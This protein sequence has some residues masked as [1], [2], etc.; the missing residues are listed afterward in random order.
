MIDALKREELRS[1]LVK[2]LGGQRVLWKEAD[3][4]PYAKDTYRIRFD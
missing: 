2:A 4:L 3:L 1:R